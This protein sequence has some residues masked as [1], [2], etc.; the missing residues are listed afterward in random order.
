MPITERNLDP[1]RPAGRFVVTLGPVDIASGA[2]S[3]TIQSLGAIP[4][5]GILRGIR[6]SGTPDGAGVNCDIWDEDAGPAAAIT[7]D[8]TLSSSADVEASP[9]TDYVLY[10][11]GRRFSLR[12]V[13]TGA[14][15]DVTAILYFEHVAARGR[16]AEASAFPFQ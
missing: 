14:A 16:E 5:A 6:F 10:D 7:A 12:A 2:G 13:A 15:T 9:S 4:W 1:E 11:V 8:A 3:G